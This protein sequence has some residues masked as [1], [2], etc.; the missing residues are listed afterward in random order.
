[1]DAP[2][3]PTPASAGSPTNPP[4][5]SP[6]GYPA[7]TGA[8]EPRVMLVVDLFDDLRAKLAAQAAAET[9]PRIVRAPLTCGANGDHIWASAPD[10]TYAWRTLRCDCGARARESFDGAIV[11]EFGYGP[12]PSLKDVPAAT[13][14][15]A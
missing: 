3:S 8:G 12:A 14:E 5:G 7:E 1:M 15:A 9:K 6:Q 4:N 11:A 13:S 2:R 10:W